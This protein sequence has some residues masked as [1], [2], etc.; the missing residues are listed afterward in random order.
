MSDKDPGGIDKGFELGEEVLG[1]YRNVLSACTING[2]QFFDYLMREM[3]QG[4]HV[5]WIQIVIDRMEETEDG[6]AKLAENLGCGVEELVPRLLAMDKASV[7]EAG[8]V[9]GIDSGALYDTEALTDALLRILPNM[10][11]DGL[12]A[13]HKVV[14]RASGGDTVSAEVTPEMTRYTEFPK[15]DD[16]LMAIRRQI[17]GEEVCPLYKL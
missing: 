3:G 17:F 12:E 8:K 6:K 10:S 9:V 14:S 7:M 2:G 16:V 5:L 11:R 13:F 4:L 1:R 15:V